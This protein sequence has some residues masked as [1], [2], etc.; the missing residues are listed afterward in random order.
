M[1]ESKPERD[2]ENE[3]TPVSRTCA[4]QLETYLVKPR[5]QKIRKQPAH[6]QTP[7]T[8]WISNENLFSTVYMEIIVE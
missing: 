6:W 1:A 7:D 8:R 5:K 2:L 4:P 3:L